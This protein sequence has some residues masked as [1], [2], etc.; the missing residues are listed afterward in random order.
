[1]TSL[2]NDQCI[3]QEVQNQTCQPLGVTHSH[4]VYEVYFLILIKRYLFELKVVYFCVGHPDVYF[5][6]N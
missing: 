1:M 3:E 2:K 6:S 4:T 5:G